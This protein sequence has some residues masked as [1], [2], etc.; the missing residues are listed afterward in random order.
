MGAYIRRI[1]LGFRVIIIL[2]LIGIIITILIIGI[3]MIGSKEPL[4]EPVKTQRSS[5]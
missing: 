3:I 5:P 2:L 1:S 4:A